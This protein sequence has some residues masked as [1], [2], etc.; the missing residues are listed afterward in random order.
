MYIQNQEGWTF[1]IEA[2]E[3]PQMQKA[4]TKNTQRLG[5]KGQNLDGN[6]MIF[7]CAGRELGVI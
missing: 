5:S 3:S 1:H 6:N 7:G 4:E 2:I